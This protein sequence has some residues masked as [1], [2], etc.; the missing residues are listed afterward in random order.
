M[1][2]QQ[3][4]S[5][6]GPDRGEGVARHLRLVH[7]RN[8]QSRGRAVVAIVKGKAI[9]EYLPS[10]QILRCEGCGASIPV[11]KQKPGR[12]DLFCVDHSECEPKREA[13]K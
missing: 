9:L 10:S 12:V 1:E 11:Q 13:Q 8:T 3:S 5:S 7:D 6:R 2:S 4:A